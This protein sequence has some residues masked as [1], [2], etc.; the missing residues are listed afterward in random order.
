MGLLFDLNCVSRKMSGSTQQL[1]PVFGNVSSWFSHPVHGS[2]SSHARAASRSL[3][4]KRVHL[5]NGGEASD[6]YLGGQEAT[7]DQ[8]SP[9]HRP[10]A[11]SDSRWVLY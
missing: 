3:R 11:G 8:S 10:V 7:D 9:L 6:A 4:N 2:G 5:L 1:T